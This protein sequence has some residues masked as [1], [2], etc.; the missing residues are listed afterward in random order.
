M[1]IIYMEYTRRIPRMARSADHERHPVRRLLRTGEAH[2]APVS[3]R[4][5]LSSFDNINLRPARTSRRHRR[6]LMNESK[7]RVYL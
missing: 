5:S 7:Y 6:R 3:V 2:S 4:W 1:C